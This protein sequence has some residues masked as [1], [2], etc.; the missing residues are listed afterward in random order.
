MSKYFVKGN[1]DKK[2]SV[3]ITIIIINIVA[4]V[5]VTVTFMYANT[6]VH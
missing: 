5:V 6:C 4:V 1:V 2:M 3:I